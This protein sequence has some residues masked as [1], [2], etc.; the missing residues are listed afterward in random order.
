MGVKLHIVKYKWLRVQKMAAILMR[1]DF[2]ILSFSGMFLAYCW[3][4]TIIRREVNF[5]NI[6]IH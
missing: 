4:I 6:N 5:F 2:K 1:Y 3:I